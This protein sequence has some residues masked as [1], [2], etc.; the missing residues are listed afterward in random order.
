MGVEIK[1]VRSKGDLR[2][3]IKFPFDLYHNNPYWIPP[4]IK[5]EKSTFDPGENP[6]YEHC[7]S[8]LWLAYDNGKVVG[9]IAAIIHKEEA[10]KEGMG[11]FGWI[12]FIDSQE[13]STKLLNVAEEWVGENNLQQIHGPL[14]FTDMD[15]EG[16]LVEGFNELGTIATIYN[17]DYYP[18]HLEELGYQK[19]VDWIEMEGPVPEEIPYRLKRKAELIQARFGF[20]SLRFT[21]TKEL[22]PYGK[23]I[24]NVLNETYKDLHGFYPLTEKQVNNYISQYLSFLKP[25]FASVI[26]S[27]EDEVVGFGI[28]MPSFSRAFQKARGRLFPFGFIHLLSALRKNDVADLY[29]MGVLPQ[30]QKFGVPVLILKDVWTEYLKA[31]IKKV[32]SNPML[33]NNYHILTQWN[34]YQN[35]ARVRRRRRCYVK[36]ID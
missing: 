20:K 18:T 14:G 31:G 19:S 24:F 3:F 21:K 30:Y 11:R 15:F 27:K 16:T 2:K 6:A 36:K 9:R 1:E 32:V 17:Y 12:D 29:L 10:S 13:V 7:D 34:E 33:E 8:R 26:L 22:L 28:S 5:D 23:G 25:E 4:L 35:T